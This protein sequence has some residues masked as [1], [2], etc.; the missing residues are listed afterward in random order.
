MSLFFIDLNVW[1]LA[2]GSLIIKE[3]GG[4][5]TDVHGQP[6][7]LATRNFVGSNGLIHDELLGKLQKARMWIE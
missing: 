6:F 2:A 4:T 7:T 5:V 1:D 3:A